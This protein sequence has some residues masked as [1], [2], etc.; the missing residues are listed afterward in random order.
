MLENVLTAWKEYTGNN[1]INVT[2]EIILNNVVPDKPLALSEEA[3]T[4]IKN[5]VKDFVKT[6]GTFKIT[7]LKSAADFTIKMVAE[8]A[9]TAKTTFIEDFQQDLTAFLQALLH[10]KDLSL[11]LDLQGNFTT[12]EEVQKFR[13][14]SQGNQV[15]YKITET[16]PASTLSKI[17]RRSV[18]MYLLIILVVAILIWQESLIH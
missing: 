16:T 3:E 15:Q 6:H 5:L 12:L 13:Y 14:Q 2:G 17:F 1:R 4:R 10:E 8:D 11:S 7:T 18:R 9:Y